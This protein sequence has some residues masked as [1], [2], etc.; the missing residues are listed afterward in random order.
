MRL[1]VVPARRRLP[2][3]RGGPALARSMSRGGIRSHATGSTPGHGRVLRWPDPGP[4]CLRR[5]RLTGEA[6]PRTRRRPAWWQAATGTR[7]APP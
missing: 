2:Y 4:S 7:A 6:G 1:T 5:S 3:R